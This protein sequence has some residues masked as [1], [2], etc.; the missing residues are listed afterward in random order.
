MPAPI[1]QVLSGTINGV[2]DTF[3]FSVPY[4]PGTVALYY[5]G[6]L[7]LHGGGNPWIESN[8]ATG[9]VRIIDAQLIPI[10]TSG[11]HPGEVLAG[12]ALDTTTEAET[13]EISELQGN[14]VTRRALSGVISADALVG[15]IEGLGQLSGLLESAPLSGVLE[16]VGQLDGRVE[17]C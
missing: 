5:N 12:F 8:P 13:V 11:G 9:E 3:F 14:I 4:T 10:A 7:L 6:Q 15:A 1:F 17:E 16:S 2:N